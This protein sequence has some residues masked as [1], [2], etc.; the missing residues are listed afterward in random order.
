MGS[1]PRLVFTC[2]ASSFPCRGLFSLSSRTK[3]QFFASRCSPTCR[4]RARTLP[5]RPPSRVKA[6]LCSSAPHR[7]Y[8]LTAAYDNAAFTTDGQ[9]DTQR[10]LVRKSWELS[11]ANVQDFIL[12]FRR[13]HPDLV[14]SFALRSALRERRNCAIKLPPQNCVLPAFIAGFSFLT[15]KSR[16]GEHD[17]KNN[18][19]RLPKVIPVDSN[20]QDSDSRKIAN[21]KRS[22]F[23]LPSRSRGIRRSED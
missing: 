9:N 6:A 13:C 17:P 15:F 19:L 4:L 16:F 22:V 21:I 11:S 20:G 12:T 8:A 14:S 1:H 2:Y 3:V 23:A 7:A 10:A 18:R 5:E